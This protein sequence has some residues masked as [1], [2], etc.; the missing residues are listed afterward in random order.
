M[1][2]TSTPEAEPREPSSPEKEKPSA[3][4]GEKKHKGEDAERGKEKE[5]PKAP[6][7]GKIPSETPKEGFSNPVV[8]PKDQE[9]VQPGAN[10]AIWRVTHDTVRR[11][12]GNLLFW[13][14][15]AANPVAAG[16]L[17]IG[18]KLARATVSKIPGIGQMYE[19]PR[20]VVTGGASKSLDVL[21]GTV[22][23][24]VSGALIV[25][26]NIKQGLT[27][28][29]TEEEKGNRLARAVEY[30]SERVGGA[31]KW[32]KETGIKGLKMGMNFLKGTIEAAMQLVVGTATIPFL[33]TQK[34]L[35]GSLKGG[36]SVLTKPIS[37]VTS[38]GA[39]VALGAGAAYLG[40]GAAGVQTYFGM[41]PKAWSY[42][43]QGWNFIRGVPIP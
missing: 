27:G 12:L 21:A 3:G 32:T 2:N 1:P 9:R 17:Y 33:T 41:F 34:V 39:L 29:V 36:W 11:P 8:A 38:V 20:A 15:V 18:D 24:P 10:S 7:S 13:G 16:T 23:A 28:E 43:V 40:W 26:H 6:A 5:S 35:A 31:L 14:A 25:G 22:S 4:E 42:V 30:V 37:T 19:I